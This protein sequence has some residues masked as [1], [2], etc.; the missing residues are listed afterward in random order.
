MTNSPGRGWGRL[1]WRVG[2]ALVVCASLSACRTRPLGASA[3]DDGAP[4]TGSTRDGST[5]GTDGPA[6]DPTRDGSTTHGDPSDA[7]GMVDGGAHSDDGGAPRMCASDGA[8]RPL[9][10]FP[11]G[12]AGYTLAPAQRLN[13]YPGD[14]EQVVLGDVTG[15][16][17]A[18]IVGEDLDKTWI[19]PQRP[20][21]SLDVPVILSHGFGNPPVVALLLA[22]ADQTLDLVV[23]SWMGI[24]VIQS[25]GGG[26]FAAANHIATGVGSMMVAD[27]NRDGHDD[28]VVP[29]ADGIVMLFGNGAGALVNRQILTNS[30]GKLGNAMAM[31]DVTGDHVPDLLAASHTTA[32]TLVIVPHDGI[33][34]L[35]PTGWT[36]LKLPGDGISGFAVGDLNGDGLLDLVAQ[37][38]NLNYDVRTRLLLGGANGFT[39]PVEIARHKYGGA[40]VVADAN[41][42]GRDDVA[43]VHAGGFEIGLVLS[44]ASGV[45]PHR[46]YAVPTAASVASHS[47]AVGDVD[48]DGCP[49]VV[50]TN[51]DGL[52]IFHGVG[53]GP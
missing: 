9:R 27:L 53:C 47:L 49:D 14:F 32:T 46:T 4:V 15:D 25:L 21:G 34:G 11:G 50:T 5:T 48:C 10:I 44:T 16:G 33:S 30:A 35:S 40:V 41:A 18:D 39:A 12:G 29:S 43:V 37:D 13:V 36:T 38:D 3:W 1:D 45:G 23:S 52:V 42:D 6:T 26:A 8:G 17:R 31:G 20:D 7:G 24:D 19:F 51:V 2:L 28:L 22:D